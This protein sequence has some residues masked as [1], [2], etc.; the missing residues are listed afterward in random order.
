[1]PG[2]TSLVASSIFGRISAR[3]SLMSSRDYKATVQ[4]LD[5]NETIYQEFKKNADAQQILDYVCEFLNI[6]EKDYFGL[7]Y[8][9]INKYRYILPMTDGQH[10]AWLCVESVTLRAELKS[11][12][13]RAL[14]IRSAI[15]VHNLSGENPDYRFSGPNVGLRFRV[16]FYPSDVTL[17]KEEITRYQ[18]FVQ[19][20]RDLLHGRLYCP[21]NE[22][23]VLGA[24]ILQSVIGDYDAEPRSPG[25][26]SEYKL[27]L[28]QTAKIEEKIAEAHKLFKGLTAAE[29]EMEFLKKASKLD[30]YGFDPYA[31]TDKQGQTLYVGVTHRGI[32]IYHVSRMIHHITWE[33]LEKVDYLGKSLFI[34]PVASYVSPYATSVEDLNGNTKSHISKSSST[35]KLHCPSATFAKHLWRHILS[36]QAFFTEN[37]AK[38]GNT[39]S[40]ISKSSS[41]LKLHCPSATFAKHLWRHILSQQA[42]FT[43]NDAKHVKPKFSKPRI[44]LLSRGSTFRFPTARVLHEIELE[45]CA[46]REGP[47]PSFTRY[48]LQRQP[49]RQQHVTVTNKYHTLPA[50]NTKSHISKSS[51]TLKLHCPSATFAKHLWRHILSQQA[52]FTENDAKHVKPK[53]SKPRIPLLSRGSTFRFPTARVLHEI[54]LEGCA[55]REGPQPSFTRYTLQRQPPRQQHVTVTN[56]YH[57]L[58]AVSLNNGCNMTIPENEPIVDLSVAHLPQEMSAPVILETE[59][60]SASDSAAV[61]KECLVSEHVDMVLTPP[62]KWL[63]HPSLKTTFT[64]HLT[65]TESL[66]SAQE[67]NRA[68]ETLPLDESLTVED[69]KPVLTSTPI[70]SPD[71]ESTRDVSTTQPSY[72]SSPPASTPV[73]LV[74]QTRDS[75]GMLVSALN[76]L[77]SFLL[78]A[79]FVIAV[80]V[81]IFE[82]H[83][84]LLG[85][86]P[87]AEMLRHSYYEPLRGYIVSLYERFAHR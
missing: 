48:T 60:E 7:R 40:H 59:E 2:D 61:S 34:A 78:L 69:I 37:D 84:S 47:Q 41:T 36:Q 77:F 65:R 68:E 57:T 26:V 75:R 51:S 50:G 29:A 11:I 10:S 5:D 66:P 70:H 17:L 4:L 58:P 46:K 22:A 56:K 19:L 8:Q 33:E 14:K 35:L 1:M 23:A 6:V 12:G 72:P 82:S 79:L 49:P 83:S 76:V 64:I 30:T 31:V 24:L 15:V 21:Q 80:L 32:Y 86:S 52:F 85:S 39:K 63:K 87:T 13:A 25:Y 18:L 45:G 54:E 43:E 73:P 42:F 9:D 53:F 74:V 67:K 28:K 62:V 27:L 38:H 71:N 3:S 44:P 20:Q 55:K 16:R 81:A